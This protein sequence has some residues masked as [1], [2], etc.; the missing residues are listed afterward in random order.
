MKARKD[1][2]LVYQIEPSGS[3]LL[4]GKGE[5]RHLC[6]ILCIS[7][8]VAMKGMKHVG[9]RTGPRRGRCLS[10]R[11]RVRD[12]SS[13]KIERVGRAKW[14]DEEGVTACLYNARLVTYW[15][16][17]FQARRV[18]W[19]SKRGDG[20]LYFASKSDAKL[21]LP[22]LYLTIS[23]Q[24]YHLN[25]PL[26]SCPRLPAWVQCSHSVWHRRRGAASLVHAF[27]G[28]NQAKTRSV[29]IMAFNYTGS[30]LL[31]QPNWYVFI[32]INL[33]AVSL[34]VSTP[35]L[36]NYARNYARALYGECSL[37]L[38]SISVTMKNK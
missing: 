17:S 2:N 35:L 27:K 30:M 6:G 34:T 5:T 21:F 22:K 23:V 10:R 3:L 31:V 37:K 18:Y 14:K 24:V 28:V 12:N 11:I 20:T 8:F 38:E 29:G 36:S 16:W 33:F 15:S 32:V 7:G 9:G 4:S 26:H 1:E 25:D 13:S 19:V